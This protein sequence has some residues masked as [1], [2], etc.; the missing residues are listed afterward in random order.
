M[1]KTMISG[2]HLTIYR[3]AI[4]TMREGNFSISL[5]ENES[6]KIEP[7]E[8]FE[9]ELIRLAAWLELRFD[10]INK[11]QEVSD[12]INKGSFLDDVLDCIYNSFRKIIPYDR[13]GC[14]LISDD[15][16]SVKAY[17]AKTNYSDTL[18]VGQG[19][20][21]PLAGSSLETILHT[22]QPRVLNDLKAYLEANPKSSSTERIVAEGIQSSLTCPL[23]SEGKPVGFL[24]FSSLEKNT[25]QREHQKI[26]LYIA[27]QVSAL[28]E[29]S[30]LYQQINDLNQQLVLALKQLKEQSIHDSL[31][32]IL[33]RGAIMEFLE[34]NLQLTERHQQSVAVIMADLDHF[35]SINDT[36]GH[37]MGDEVLSVVAKEI[38][39][40]LRAYDRVGRFGG[41][42][43]L[44]V[45]GD[46]DENR[47]LEIAERIRTAVAALNFQ[48]QEQQLSVSISM[49][50]TSSNSEGA[51]SAKKVLSKADSALYQAKHDGRNRV[52]IA[53]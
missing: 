31:T 30:S 28:I 44:I 13:I 43:F 3:D 10:E 21:A 32:G 26:F 46:T 45:L 35:K 4:R 42:E 22:G 40:H 15:Y 19:F 20:T 9:T 18:T 14:A 16:Q 12:E 2:D 36:Y 7:L 5:P 25:Y 29:K 52:L 50:I 23:V 8:E 47:A 51:D 33:N 17:W 6:S 27:R 1:K 24:F 38:S 48:C 49:G 41:E 39:S 53:P 37:L 11:L 34:Q